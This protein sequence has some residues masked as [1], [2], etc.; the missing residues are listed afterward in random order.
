MAARRCSLH[1]IDFPTSVMRCPVCDEATDWLNSVDPDPDWEHA[2]ELCA[3]G[4]PSTEAEK[5]ERWRL[6][7][8]LD[9]GYGVETAESLAASDADLHE[10]ANLIRDGCPLPLAARI[11]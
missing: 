9:L 11:V 8:A 3:G 7:V 1:G 2:V 5:I 10:L 4:R 6:T